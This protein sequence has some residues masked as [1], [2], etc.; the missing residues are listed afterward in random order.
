MARPRSFDERAVLTI[1][2]DR[3]R[4]TGYAATSIDDVAAAVGLGKGSL[5]GAFGDKYQLFRRVF[6]DYCADMGTMAH[7][8]FTGPDDGALDRLRTGIRAVVAAMTEGEVS[9]GC[10]L[11]RGIAELG[12]RD[13]EIGARAL[14]AF[15]MLESLLAGCIEQAQ[16]TGDLDADA[17]PKALAGM[18]FAV[19]RGV[20]SL[21]RAG[22]SQDQLYARLDTAVAMLPRPTR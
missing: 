3:F 10:L 15:E 21:A 8:L 12:D 2:R 5:Y 17:D 13:P 6:D 9:G 20:E 7:A 19:M 14:E 4:A 1:A 11:A 22:L 18:L 16:R